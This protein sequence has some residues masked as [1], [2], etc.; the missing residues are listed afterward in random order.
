MFMENKVNELNEN[1]IV[2]IVYEKI[3]QYWGKFPNLWKVIGKDEIASEVFIDL[4]KP[5]KSDGIR[6]IDHYLK[7][8]GERSIKPLIGMIVY[9]NLIAQART[10][11]STG[12]RNVEARRNVY[13]A[14]SLETPIGGEDDMCLGDTVSSDIDVSKEID[15]MILYE[16]IPD[17]IV[18][19]IFYKVD[20]GY[21][22]VSY[23]SLL[24][25]I[26]DGYNL[27][28]IS[29]RLYKKTE[30]GFVNIRSVSNIIKEMREHLKSYLNNEYSFTESNYEEGGLIL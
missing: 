13:S 15:Y 27:S 25:D 3:N 4:Y 11:Y 7:T 16:D 14:I 12:N 21:M 10:I 29:E 28:Q 2:E 24:K 9:N 26:I 5:R 1:E 18:D 19:G 22:L 23:K 17:K 20:N 6:A 8:K 30:K